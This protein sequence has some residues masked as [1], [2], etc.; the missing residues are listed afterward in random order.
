[1]SQATIWSSPY[2]LGSWAQ[3]AN[4]TKIQFGNGIFTFDFDKR[5]GPGRWPDVPFGSGNLEFTLG[6]CL[7]IQGHWNCSAVIQYW[8]G[9]PTEAPT[10]IA[11]NWFYDFRWGPMAGYQPAYG[12]E[13]GIFVGAGNLRSIT[14]C[15]VRC[16]SYVFERS[17]VAIIPW[18]HNYP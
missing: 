4:I 3:T 6:M 15:K 2:N 1:M 5:T 13:V 18:G 11:Q 12:E 8:F 16:G 14:D 17:N 10:S 7:N 9:R